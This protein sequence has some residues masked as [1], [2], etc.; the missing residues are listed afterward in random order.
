M[1][2]SICEDG[3]DVFE[4][5]CYASRE[6]RKG[7]DFLR[8]RKRHNLQPRMERCSEY[9]IENPEENRGKWGENLKPVF[10]EIGCGK[11]SFTC[12]L[13]KAELDCNII[14]IEKVP[15]AMILA[16][17]RAKEAG[18]K[19]V[20]FVN[21][22]AEKLGEV[23][24][25]GEIDRIFI[26]FCDPWPKSRD[27]KFRLTAPAFLRNYAELLAEDGELCFKTDNLPLFE[28][29]VCRFQEE[30]WELRDLTRDLHKEGVNGILTDYEKKFMRDGIPIKSLTAVKKPWTKGLSAGIPPRLRDAA[31]TDAYSMHGGENR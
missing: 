11:G 3:L 2:F 9:L 27:A 8:M 15:D 18:L 7:C 29:S 19:N 5:L 25:S 1:L 4:E 21:L 14:A 10:L 26:N 12:E 17:E 23:F 6:E 30:D 28:W 20:R 22:D 31:L 16:M 24:G 13:A